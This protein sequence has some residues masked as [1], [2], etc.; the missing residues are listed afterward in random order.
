MVDHR[1]PRLWEEWERNADHAVRHEVSCSTETV[2][3][4]DYGEH[5]SV[6]MKLPEFARDSAGLPD[7]ACINVVESLPGSAAVMPLRI[8]EFHDT[9]LEFDANTVWPGREG[10]IAVRGLYN[11][12]RIGRSLSSIRRWCFVKRSPQFSGRRFTRPGMISSA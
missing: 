3:A 2:A 8:T 5:V 9:L 11:Q 10:I 6:T 4:T 12:T 7:H 1:F